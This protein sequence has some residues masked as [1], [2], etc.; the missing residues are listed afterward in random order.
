MLNEI[1]LGFNDVLIYYLS[2][3]LF[4]IV[5]YFFGAYFGSRIGLRK[6][7]M[8]SIPFQLLHYFLL[9]QLF[10]Y[11]LSIVF[12]G[13]IYG[14]AEGLF[15][16]AY[17]VNFTYFSDRKHRGQEV[18]LHYVIAACIGVFGPFIGGILL[19]YM[20]F[21]IL[22]IVVI[23]LLLLSI[24]PLLHIENKEYKARL[25]FRDIFHERHL[26]YTP[27]FFVQGMRS[28]VSGVFWPIFV[29]FIVKGY[30]SLGL[31]FS[32]AS[33]FSSIVVFVIGNRIDK[34]DKNYKKRFTDIF[35]FIHGLISFVKTIVS[36]LFHV[37]IVGIISL[38][39]YGTTEVSLDALA[40]NK[41]KKNRRVVEFFVFRDIILNFARVFTIGI[42]F[43]SGLDMISNLKFSF[44]LLGVASV[45][46][47][48]LAPAYTSVTKNS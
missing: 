14:F 43:F 20:N 46:Q 9:Y 22:F 41:A 36:E 45:V 33:V 29:F 6:I 16:L 34:F 13:A 12:L 19:R 42:L 15:W 11:D 37:Y 48:L 32:V 1:K 21:Y 23:L 47:K 26:S 28:I 27:R 31:V 5:G 30:F 40:F 7:I 38:I 3:S 10:Y 2:L 44:I 24:L 4:L 8:L 39:T 35:S 18:N 17:N 25:S